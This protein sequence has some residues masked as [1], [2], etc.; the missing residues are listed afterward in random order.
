M[1]I[2][3]LLWKLHGTDGAADPGLGECPRAHTL[4]GSLFSAHTNDNQTVVADPPQLQAEE[5]C[6]GQKSLVAGTW[7]PSGLPPDPGEGRLFAT[8]DSQTEA[9]PLQETERKMVI[10]KTS[11][12]K[13][14]ASLGG[15]VDQEYGEV[16]LIHAV[17]GDLFQQWNV[18]HPEQAVKPGDRIV[19]VNGVR[20]DMLMLKDE[21]RKSQILELVVKRSPNAPKELVPFTISN[22]RKVAVLR[23]SD[24]TS[25]VVRYLEPGVEFLVGGAKIDKSDGRMYLRL[26]DGTGWVPTHSRRDVTKKVVTE[27]KGTDK[28]DEVEIEDDPLS[29]EE[30]SPESYRED[31]AI[32]AQSRALGTNFTGAA[33][34]GLGECPRAHTLNGSLYSADSDG[35]R[36]MDNFWEYCLS[37]NRIEH[38]TCEQ[39]PFLRFRERIDRPG[40]KGTFRQSKLC[41]PVGNL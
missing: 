7:R 10:D 15:S 8:G 9:K 40:K 5:G 25:A 29:E 28:I 35:L 39:R 16:L 20:N 24:V 26:T 22:N 13:L 23:D 3:K 14:G 11:G 4:N 19:E 36:S 33:D 18:N 12:R 2:C 37:I 34:P 21:C 17:T 27:V 31:G 1:G 30:S 6:F 32:G 38:P 41:T